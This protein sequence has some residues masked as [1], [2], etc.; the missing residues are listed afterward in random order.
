[1]G[2]KE[3]GVTHDELLEAIK[4]GVSDAIIRI[5]HV[6]DNPKNKEWNLEASIFRDQVLKAIEDGVEKGTQNLQRL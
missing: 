6:T 2:L 5:C 1:M 3:L 4:N